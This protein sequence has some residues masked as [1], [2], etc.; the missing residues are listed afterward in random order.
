MR[1]LNLT[2]IAAG[3]SAAADVTAGP[4][5]T[6]YLTQA[7]VIATVASASSPVATVKLQGSNDPPPAENRANVFTP[8][9]WVDVPDASASISANGTVGFQTPWAFRWA[10]VVYD[11][12]S[13]TGG[14]VTAV[15]NFSNQAS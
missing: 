4:Y 14:T 5:Q 6:G 2:A 9:N 7:S 13:G 10:Q 1:V 8:T 12:T 15:V 3:T 11:Y